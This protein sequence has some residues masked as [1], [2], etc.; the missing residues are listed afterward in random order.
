MKLCKFK[1]CTY[2]VC[3]YHW[4]NRKFDNV[5]LT[6][7][8]TDPKCMKKKNVKIE[9]EDERDVDQCRREVIC[10][11]TDVIYPNS[12][13]AGL[14]LDISPRSIRKCCRGEQVSAG[15]YTWTYV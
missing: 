3:T 4:I 5:A 1:N 14:E 13:E 8:T 7:K 6:D 15:G 10:I 12:R 11:E 2:R 9:V